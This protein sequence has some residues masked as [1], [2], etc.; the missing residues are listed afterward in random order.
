MTEHPLVSVIT[1]S[2][3]QGIFIDETI[4]SVITQD[5]PYI[6]HIV[7]D[8]GSTDNTLD[9]L[10]KYGDKITWV[11]EKDQGQSDAIN[12]GFNLSKGDIWAWLNSDDTYSPGAIKK[13]VDYFKAN[14]GIKLVHGRGCIINEDSSIIR[15]Y[16]SDPQAGGNLP[17][18]FF[19]CQPAMFIS[20]D[21]TDRIGLLDIALHYC[22]DYD[23][24]IRIG[25]QYEI[26]YLNEHLANVRLYKGTKSSDFHKMYGE[27]LAVQ[28]KYFGKAS[29]NYAY[30]YT[31]ALLQSKIKKDK[32]V[33]GKP[34]LPVRLLAIMF[35]FYKFTQINGKIPV[36]EFINWLNTNLR[37]SGS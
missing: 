7:I 22:M 10:K 9:I 36:A 34:G 29:F 14:P 20:R 1:P 37:L 23:F 11:S 5:Y 13:V 32:L 16:K 3:N 19:I 35:S 21:I 6:E 33:I 4:R 24:V 26:G 8:G 17:E 28:K 27:V 31:W 2:Y 30:T 18:G 25:R 15:S 12:K